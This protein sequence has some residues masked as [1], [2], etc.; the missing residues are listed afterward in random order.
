VTLQAPMSNKSPLKAATIPAKPPAT[1]QAVYD[2]LLADAEAAQAGG[3]T[4][5]YDVE[6]LLD[7]VEALSEVT[8]EHPDLVAPFTKKGLD[9]HF[10]GALKLAADV[11][12][13]CSESVPDDRR[14]WEQLT[15]AQ[16]DKVLAI[17][18][19]TSG[20]R[21]AAGDAAMGKDKAQARALGRGRSMNRRSVVSVRAAVRAFNVG[22]ASRKELL[23][24]AGIGDSELAEMR[25]NEKVMNSI[26][27]GKNGARREHK[28][29]GVQLELA[30]LVLQ[31]AFAQ[32]RAR[33]RVAVKNDPVQLAKA[34]E[35]LP[36]LARSKAK[37]APVAASDA[38]K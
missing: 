18:D 2:A 26:A 3:T 15:P 4:L 7:A 5:R 8:T 19:Q 1:S 29:L 13:K 22:A 37:A 6:E 20:Y 11:L 25:A 23:A 24:K 33:A 27:R 14:R 10:F 34:L 21:T 30:G 28:K 32:Y 16:R 9:T 38:T 17:A 31:V 36:K 35:V 12:S